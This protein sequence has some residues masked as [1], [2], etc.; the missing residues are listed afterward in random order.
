M[1]LKNLESCET[2]QNMENNLE[3]A[4][5]F[6]TIRILGNDQENSGQL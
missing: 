2:I 3:K 4:S 6:D 5:G 1:I